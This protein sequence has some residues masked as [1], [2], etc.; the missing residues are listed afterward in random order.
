MTDLAIT[1][2]LT[3]L[4]TI[5]MDRKSILPPQPRPGPGAP[6]SN[7]N[8]NGGDQSSASGGTNGTG[9]QGNG[10]TKNIN[11]LIIYDLGTKRPEL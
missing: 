8:N 2:D 10:A 1:P 5:G 3:R 4:V 7:N 9:N 11:K 6:T